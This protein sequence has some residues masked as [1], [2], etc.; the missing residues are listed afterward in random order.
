MLPQLAVSIEADTAAGRIQQLEAIQERFKAG[1]AKQWVVCVWIAESA[2]LVET[3]EQIEERLSPLVGRFDVT[4][5]RLLAE[6]FVEAS[7]HAILPT[8]REHLLNSGL[9]LADQLLLASSPKLCKQVVTAVG[10]F[11][12]SNPGQSV[13]ANQYLGN[14]FE[15]VN[16]MM[17]H[18]DVVARATRQPDG[19]ELSELRVLGRHYCL[20]LR[21]WDKGLVWLSKSTNWRIASAAER[22]WSWGKNQ[23]LMNSRSS[24]TSGLWRQTKWR[25]V[26]QMRSG[27]MRS[28]CSSKHSRKQHP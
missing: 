11:A 9:R 25:V 21:R 23:R 2:W 19:L 26:W 4:S 12:S 5:Q 6:T 27:C 18:A 14:Y 20:L 10:P 13:Q 7:S 22:S 1:S 15:A 16:L 28:N 17:R 3:L 8:T 24:S